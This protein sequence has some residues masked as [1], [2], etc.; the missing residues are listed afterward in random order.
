MHSKWFVLVYSDRTD[1]SQS[2]IFCFLLKNCSSFVKKK[3][4]MAVMK[5]LK[6]FS[7]SCAESN[8]DHHHQDVLVSMQLVINR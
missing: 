8:G 3:I 6:E 2:E 1:K 7:E 4:K 5:E